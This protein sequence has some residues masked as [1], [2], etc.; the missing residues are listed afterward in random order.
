MF[1]YYYFFGE[2]RAHLIG[3]NALATITTSLGT[4]PFNETTVRHLLSSKLMALTKDYEVVRET[5]N[6][7]HAPGQS[8]VSQYLQ[9]LQKQHS[10][11]P[12]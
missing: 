11:S 8:R 5:K 1:L 6:R 3:P 10:V 12:S 4:T 7:K 2:L 9:I